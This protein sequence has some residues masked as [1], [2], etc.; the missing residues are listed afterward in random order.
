MIEKIQKQVSWWVGVISIGVILGASLQFVRAWVEPISAP[1]GDNIGAPINTSGMGQIKNGAFG[2]GLDVGSTNSSLVVYSG[3]VGIGTDDPRKKLDVRGPVHISGNLGI[4]TQTPG[5]RLGVNGN[6][7]FSGAVGIGGG[8][9]GLGYVKADISDNDQHLLISIN[10]KFEGSWPPSSEEAGT[11]NLQSSGHTAGDLAFVT[12]NTEAMRVTKMGNVG[13]GTQSPS[14]RMDIVGSI[15]MNNGTQGEGKVLTS[16]ASGKGNWKKC[17]V[18]HRFTRLNDST[19]TG[20]EACSKIL[21]SD[22]VCTSAG[23]GVDQYAF[24]GTNILMY[25]NPSHTSSGAECIRF[26]CE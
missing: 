25:D 2:I 14:V 11:V 5:E 19:T 4:D 16:D 1:P 10:K 7:V 21:G 22:W 8:I 20:N 6:A 24:C 12:G 23:Y 13:I 9:L 17:K 3:R 15:R 26:V 18:E